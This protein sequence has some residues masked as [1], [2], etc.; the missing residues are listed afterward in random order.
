MKKQRFVCKNCGCRFVVEVLEEGEAEERRL[1]AS[2]V[3]CR[4]CGSTSLVRD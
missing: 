2:P 1:P 4:E 3:R